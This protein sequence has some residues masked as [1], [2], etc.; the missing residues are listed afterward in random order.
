MSDLATVVGTDNH[1]ATTVPDVPSTAQTPVP[2]AA[3]FGTVLPQGVHPHDA[4]VPL[5]PGVP[6]DSNA[7]PG[8]GHLG[9]QGER[10]RPP[11]DVEN[12]EA[13]AVYQRSAHDWSARQFTVNSTSGPIQ[14]AG[15]LRGCL[16][17]VIWVPTSAA[18]GCVIDPTE[19][20]IQAGA[21][22]TLSPGD[23]IELPTEGAVWAGV[24][25]GQTS[26]TVYVVR[27]FNPPGGGLGLSSG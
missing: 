9:P 1:P 21:G 11:W 25:V 3:N 15:R 18:H 23:S 17:T 20:A 8:E 24:I 14:I 2:P 5:T 10:R 22:V 26:G 16:S 19:G 7:L 12:E 13:L 27:F 6:I 4:S